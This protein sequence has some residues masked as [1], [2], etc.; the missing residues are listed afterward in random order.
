MSVFLFMFLLWHVFV[1]DF[2]RLPHLC[3]KCPSLEEDEGLVYPKS[4]RKETPGGLAL[5]G[6]AW[7]V[8]IAG[9]SQSPSENVNQPQISK[10]S[11]TAMGMDI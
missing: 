9:P 3:Q 11:W 10:H 4:L 6:G 8:T 2:E 5:E 1:R 7:D